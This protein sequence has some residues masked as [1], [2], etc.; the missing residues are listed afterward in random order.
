MATSA[1]TM[2]GPHNADDGRAIAPWWHTVLLVGLF[3]LITAAGAVF[4]HHVQTAPGTSHEHPHLAP[5]YLS[6][7]A[8][9]WG[10]VLYVRKGL[11]RRGV[12]L[13]DL[14]GRR[15]ASWRDIV[16]DLILAFGFWSLWS[17]GGA[18]WQ[19][20]VRPDHAASIQTLLP[21]GL[22]EGVLW[23]GLSISAGICE[24][25]VF[26]G[27]FL[28]QFRA[29]TPG[30]L[31]AI[32]LQ[33]ALFGISHGYQGAQATIEIAAYGALM[34]LLATWRGSLRPGMIAHA[35]TDIFNGLLAR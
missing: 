17:L 13:H 12:L 21:R 26:R 31:P 35:W 15:W 34:G 27:Y 25:I 1:E 10:L 9:E 2:G 18:A 6:L 19:R 3:L 23:V 20:W 33:A 28:V 24:E 32:L 14:I 16:R 8:M 29:L 7:I 11:W 22:I 30:V 5:L 4:Q